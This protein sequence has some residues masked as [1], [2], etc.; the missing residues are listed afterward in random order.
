MMADVISPKPG[1]DVFTLKR[2]TVTYKT[3]LEVWLETLRDEYE[4]EV[5]RSPVERGVLLGETRTLDTCFAFAESGLTVS[6]STS[7]V[8]PLARIIVDPALVDFGGIVTTASSVR[9]TVRQRAF[10]AVTRWNLLEGRLATLLANRRKFPSKKFTLDD[11]DVL[12]VIIDRWSRLPVADPQNLPLST[13]VKAL[14]LSAQQHKALAKT[15]ATDLR[16]LAQVL[17]SVPVI[18]R[19]NKRVADRPPPVTAARATRAKSVAVPLPLSAQEARE[20]LRT[21]A[22]SLASGQA[23]SPEA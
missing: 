23:A 6:G 18:D 20:I 14:G 3:F 13:A 2:A 15:G 10:E 11:D 19:Y 8:T 5:A 4:R 21:I 12:A 9:D 7:S 16:G 22:A 17:R 1:Q